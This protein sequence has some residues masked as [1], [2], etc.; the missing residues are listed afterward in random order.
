MGLPKYAEHDRREHGCS[1]YS[2]SVEQIIDR[3]VAAG[4][5]PSEAAYVT[6]ALR[7]YADHIDAQ[8]AIADRAASSTG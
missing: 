1:P 2:G 3:Q 5:A 6:E 7:A 4:R 8:V